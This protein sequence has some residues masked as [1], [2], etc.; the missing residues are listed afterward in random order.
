MNKY[1]VLLF[2]GYILS[3]GCSSSDKKVFVNTDEEKILT[4]QTS[5]DSVIEF[6]KSIN[7]NVKFKALSIS[8]S[9]DYYPLYDKYKTGH[10]PITVEREPVGYLPLH[11][12]YFYTEN[13]KIVRL[14]SYNWEKEAFS[15]FNKKLE[16][17]RGESSKRSNYE[18]EYKRL[19]KLVVTKLGSPKIS[20]NESKIVKSNSDRGD[21]VTQNTVWDNEN[22]HAELNLIFESMTYRIR[23]TLYWK[24]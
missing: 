2:I 22:F 19:F 6:E 18:Q 13:D 17:F 1:F 5:V 7:S 15:D 14:I 11:V 8:L 20:D 10:K 4:A 3:L 24:K 21:Y 16:L 12:D 23:M 9:Q